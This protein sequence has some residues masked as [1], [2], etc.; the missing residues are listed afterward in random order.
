MKEGA[1][2]ESSD[3]IDRK[4]IEMVN[5]TAVRQLIIS[6][7]EALTNNFDQQVTPKTTT[8]LTEFVLPGILNKMAQMMHTAS[9]LQ[10]DVSEM[11]G[12]HDVLN[13]RMSIS[14]QRSLAL[15]GPG[16][17]VSISLDYLGLMSPEQL[18]F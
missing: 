17:C 18:K 16:R 8:I 11:P 7:E 15:G 6:D 9:P 2:E 4:I 5:L 3:P 13:H 14:S 10:A 12:G 1:Y